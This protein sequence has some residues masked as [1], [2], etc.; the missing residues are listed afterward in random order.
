MSGLAAILAGHT[1]PGVY[2]WHSAFHPP[3]VK[4]TVEHAGWEFGY[5]DGWLAQTKSE[6]LVAVGKA[7]KF[8]SYYGRNLDALADCLRW[9]PR[10]DVMGTVLLWDGWGPLATDDRPAF[11]RVLAV[12][13]D[14]VKAET[15]GTF[16]VLLRGEGPDSVRLPSVD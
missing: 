12:F 15:W 4:H 6:F 3:D 7:L 5:V 13:E 2:R 8:P 9:E 11:D 1:E 10:T 16:V 14:R